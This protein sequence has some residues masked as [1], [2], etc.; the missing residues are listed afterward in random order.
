MQETK[1]AQ[2]RNAVREG[3]VVEKRLSSIRRRLA[4]V[5]GVCLVV[6]LPVVGR[7][8]TTGSGVVA[9]GPIDTYAGGGL[10][11][12]PARQAGQI[13]AGVAVAVRGGAR[14]A[15]VSDTA[16]HVVR[17][18][19]PAGNATVV[20][21]NGLSGYS[22]DGGPATAARL[23]NPHGVGVD[24]D[25]NL[26]IAD[27]VNHAVRE[28]VPGPDGVVNGG[29]GETVTTI[30]GP[31]VLP[32]YSGPYAM[33][34]DSRTSPPDIFISDGIVVRRISGSEITIYAG[35][36]SGTN[37]PAPATDAHFDVV[38]KGL[39]L[40]AAGNLFIAAAS[41]VWRVVGAASVDGTHRID[42]VVGGGLNP[43]HPALATAPLNFHDPQ[44]LA[45]RSDPVDPTAVTLYIAATG[46]H[47]IYKVAFTFLEVPDAGSMRSTIT[48]EAGKELTPGFRGEGVDVATAKD[49]SILFD[50]PGGLALD[51]DG[52]L[53]IAD[54]NNHRLRFI[55]A[56]GTRR[57]VTIS[58]PCC[59]GEGPARTAQLSD[60]A[61]ASLDGAGNLFVA[62]PLNNRVLRVDGVL[63]ADGTHH[64]STYA[65]GNF[66][67]ELSGG[68]TAATA[69]LGDG[70]PATDAVLRSPRGVAVDG[71]GN[72]FIADTGH[73]V[74]RMVDPSGTISTVAGLC[75]DV[76][77]YAEGDE[78]DA[79]LARL[80]APAGVAVDG[81]GNLFIADTGSSAIRKVDAVPSPDGTR[82][83]T[84]VAGAYREEK[85]PTVPRCGRD[86]GNGGDA[87]EA[88]LLN[89]LSVAVDQVGDLFIADTY[90]DRV[91]KVDAA[92]S[93]DGTH[94]IT[95]VAGL[96]TRPAV[97]TYPPDTAEGDGGSST[98]SLLRP[99]AVALDI[100]GN[101]F[102]ADNRA[103]KLKNLN[104]IP[105]LSRVRK[106]DAALS[107][108]GTHHI[109]TFAGG[110]DPPDGLGDTLVSTQAALSGPMGVA[111]APGGEVFV[112]DALQHR[113]R[114]VPGNVRLD[115]DQVGFP[116]R[117]L[118]TTSAPVP[119]SITNTSASPLSVST[120]SAGAD[121]ADFAVIA[122]TCAG[123]ELAPATS[124]SLSLVFSPTAIGE[125][126]A[127]LSVTD[128][129][130]LSHAATLSG[131]GLAPPPEVVGPGGGSGG[132]SGTGVGSGTGTGTGGVGGTVATV[133]PTPT[134]LAK[135]YWLVASDGGIFAFGGAGFFGSTGAIRLNRPIVAMAATPTAKGYWLVASDGG[136]FAFGD[137]RFF[138][139][140]GAIKLNSPIVAMASTPSGKGYWLV[141]ADGGIFAFGDAAFSGSTGAIRLARPIVGMAPTPSGKGY[142][143]VAGDGGIFAFG[144]AAFKGSTGAIRLAQ[145]I[146]GMASTPSGA[147]YWLV[148]ADGGI[149]AFGDAVF[150]GSTGAIRLN[151]PIAG[152][153]ATPKGRGYFLVASDGGI[154]AFGDAVFAGSTG[155]VKLNSPIVSMLLPR[156]E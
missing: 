80:S 118:G 150:S 67:E 65:G 78:G 114:L 103:I 119:L 9:P 140:T 8:A 153:A 23:N 144:D 39:A 20:A 143:L 59:G 4:V 30:A 95:T 46:S 149:F 18:I 38:P 125:R 49:D 34:V 37:G 145:P 62:D 100:L 61:S 99:T 10:G 13:P 66:A 72:L 92:L 96:T 28:V 12:G 90:N 120:T 135:G 63:S 147:G 139:S 89:P 57:I 97:D 130:G 74:I 148:A 51:P 126:T 16:Y 109:T 76:G 94:H 111:V 29:P 64:A 131:V 40:D 142:W 154:F 102:V 105:G 68:A 115:T 128:S 33:A 152:M 112:S 155:A 121:S 101:L 75:C 137:A 52:D 136:V 41:Q 124:C 122:D 70:G 11:N 106:I 146:V 85:C 50:G 133:V 91:K 53:F 25:G 98:L 132:G 79:K 88:P 2:R 47:V 138:G 71:A 7:A 54:T 116:P 86:D 69:P 60:S 123:V 55:N 44:G 141:A 17:V 81:T 58:G 22:G 87:L 104:P 83:I 43:T 93:A 15:Y 1:A 77:R 42:L 45:A 5:V 21:G 19:D 134:P 35:G 56:A 14:Y 36:G 156:L 108:D 117:V 107:A 3:D 6:A 26:Y 113:V 48:L 82:H 31:G 151:R 27:T 24:A 84:T 73:N 127:T 129:G 110:G 32:G